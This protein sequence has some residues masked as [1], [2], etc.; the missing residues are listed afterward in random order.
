VNRLVLKKACLGFLVKRAASPN[1]PFLEGLLQGASVKY[2]Q[3]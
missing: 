1:E 2:G 3:Q